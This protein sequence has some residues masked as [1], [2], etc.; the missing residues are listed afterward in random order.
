MKGVTIMEPSCKMIQPSMP[1]I[2]F[3]QHNYD[4]KKTFPTREKQ[5]LALLE[6]FENHKFRAKPHN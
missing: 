4:E 1:T 2:N 5:T 3:I 6:W